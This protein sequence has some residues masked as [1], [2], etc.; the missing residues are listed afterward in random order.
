MNITYREPAIG[1]IMVE[2]VGMFKISGRFPG[3]GH[4][5]IFVVFNYSTQRKLLPEGIIF[6][7]NCAVLRWQGTVNMV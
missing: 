2:Q 5:S 6:V 7:E 4:L 1:S 3:P